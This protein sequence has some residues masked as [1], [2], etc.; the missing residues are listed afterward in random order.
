MASVRA[1]SNFI[2][3]CGKLKQLKRQG[4]LRYNIKNPESVAGHSWRLGI[5]CLIIGSELEKDEKLDISKMLKMALLHDLAE[6]EVGD[7]TPRD[8]MLP[9]EKLLVEAE[10]MKKIV[11]GIDETGELYHIWGEYITGESR[12]ALLVNALDKLEMAVQAREYEKGGV[13]GLEEFYSFEEHMFPEGI[14]RDLYN[15]LK[16]W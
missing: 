10:G 15:D 13:E 11:E 1:I 8:G 6:A 14:I 3:T 16:K 12:E 2:L 4:W 5:L 7:I 9:E